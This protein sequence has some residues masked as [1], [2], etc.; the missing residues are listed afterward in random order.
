MERRS[1]HRAAMARCSTVNLGVGPPTETVETSASISKSVW[2]GRGPP[3][4]H[5]VGT[6]PSPVGSC[7]IVGAVMA[8]S[9]LPGLVTFPAGMRPAGA[10]R[11][12]DGDAD[13]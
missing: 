3:T 7:L 4:G 2:V 6:D 11:L 10:Y 9:H 12:L 1:W 13:P 5:R 8:M